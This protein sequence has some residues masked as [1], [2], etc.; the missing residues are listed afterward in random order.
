MNKKVL[1]VS[2]SYEEK[3]K[4]LYEDYQLNVSKMLEE[5]TDEKEY[6]K[7]YVKATEI[8]IKKCKE[9]KDEFIIDSINAMV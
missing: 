6:I 9:L 8:Y 1:K 2:K 4:K 7:H 5:Y 3:M